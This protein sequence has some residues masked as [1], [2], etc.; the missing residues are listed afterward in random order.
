MTSGRKGIG[1]LQILLGIIILLLVAILA[2][3]WWVNRNVYAKTFTPV[4]LQEDELA[5]LDV[6]LNTVDPSMRTTRISVPP[7]APESYREDFANRRIVFT[8][9]ELNAV[10]AKDPD[11]ARTVAID[12]S[13]G[14]VTIRI[15]APMND[16]LPLLGGKTFKLTMGLS[17]GYTNEQ[18]LVS[19]RGISM[20]GIPLPSAWWGGI[21][22][23]NLIEEFGH[24]NGFWNLF[25]RGVESLQVTDD[26]FVLHLKE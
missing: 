1:C 14:L 6:K 23:K 11:T 21:K 4:E 18:T 10:L 26:T 12:L 16:D 7:D 8:E 15:L 9:R 22:N 13:E 5:L 25:S 20:G 19:I 2:S 17:V 24:S 3:I